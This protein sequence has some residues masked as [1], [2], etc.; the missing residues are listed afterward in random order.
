MV[1]R[2][3]SSK[4]QTAAFDWMRYPNSPIISMSCVWGMNSMC[5]QHSWHVV[6]ACNCRSA[7]VCVFPKHSVHAGI[8]LAEIADL[9]TVATVIMN[10]LSTD[11]CL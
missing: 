2:V 1:P 6:T 4:K 11:A 3:Q 10:M 9:I 8:M 7:A 5:S